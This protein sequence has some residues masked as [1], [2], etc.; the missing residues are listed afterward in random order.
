MERRGRQIMAF[1]YGR[2]FRRFPGDF[3]W[4]IRVV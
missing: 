4:S 2:L 3:L 1:R